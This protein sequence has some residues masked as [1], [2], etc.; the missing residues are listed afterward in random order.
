MSQEVL[1]IQESNY[2]FLVQ[3]LIKY[4]FL[5]HSPLRNRDMR[6]WYALD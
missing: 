1:P 6:V 4:Q 2:T 5:A 3:K